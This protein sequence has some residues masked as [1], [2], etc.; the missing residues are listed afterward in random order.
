[1]QKSTIQKVAAVTVVA[2]LL[3]G[4]LYLKG[5]ALRDTKPSSDTSRRS[6]PA[7]TD[8]AP[9]DG[10]EADKAPRMVLGRVWL[11]KYPEKRADEITMV[12]FFAGGIGIEMK[13][14]SFKRTIEIFELERQKDKLNITLLHDKRKANVKFKVESCDEKRPFDA[15]LTFDPP[16]N[17]K[18]KLYGW[19]HEEEADKQAPWIREW[20]SSAEA[21]SKA[22]P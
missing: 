13:G 20:K 17:G 3:G 4:V 21:T 22:S 11:D 15:C 6:E 9:A 16:F 19:L 14:S 18:T 5:G 10:D 12:L 7:R 2:A 8:P 1:M